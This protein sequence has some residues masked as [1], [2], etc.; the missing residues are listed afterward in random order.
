MRSA[1]EGLQQAA[2]VV[3]WRFDVN[4]GSEAA[5]ELVYGPEG[6]WVKLFRRSP[7]YIKTDLLRDGDVPRR[8]VTLDYWKSRQAYADFRQGYAAEYA[9]LDARCGALTAGETLIGTFEAA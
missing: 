4:P 7:G 8:Y 9:A 6:D 5:F 1:T 3:A 2:Y